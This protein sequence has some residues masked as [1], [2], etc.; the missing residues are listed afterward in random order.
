MVTELVF[1]SDEYNSTETCRVISASGLYEVNSRVTGL[2]EGQKFRLGYTLHIDQSWRT[3]MVAIDFRNGINSNRVILEN[4]NEGN[5]NSESIDATSFK[6][7]IDIDLSLTPFTNT[8]PIRRLNFDLDLTQEI[9]VLYFDLMNF[10]IYPA[11]QRYRKVSEGVYNFQTVPKDFEA[12]VET[13][14]EGFV[15]NYP[16]LFKRMRKTLTQ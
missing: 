12:I 3:K 14:D 16:G 10:E 1:E 9:S 13:D 5:W 4:D 6:N 8:L 7:C 15:I 11:R 2:Y